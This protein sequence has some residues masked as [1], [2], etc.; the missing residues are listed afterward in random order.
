M[1]IYLIAAVPKN[2]VIGK[3]NKM[4]WHLPKDLAFFKNTTVHNA[5]IMG[6]K[7]YESLGTY[8]PLPDRWNLILTRDPN[9]KPKNAN[10]QTKVFTTLKAAVLFAETNGFEKV[11]IAGGGEI[12]KHALEQ[13]DF[14]IAGAYITEVY[15]EIEGDTY[16]PNLSEFWN[17]KH[18]ELISSH[19]KDG[20]HFTPFDIALYTKQEIASIH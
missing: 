1:N 19:E 9:Y 2:R 16:F 7:T 5:V 12:Y 20:K 6:R 4:P 8:A 10:E 15:A 11:F 14:P 3:Q 18:R 17:P 13:K